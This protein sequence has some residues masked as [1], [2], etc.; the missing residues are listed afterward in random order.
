MS[1]EVQLKVL[2]TRPV[3]RIPATINALAACCITAVCDPMLTIEPLA[4]SGVEIPTCQALA[5]T[6]VAAAELLGN[7]VSDVTI[8]IY[9]VG[10]TTAKTALQHG[11][12][13]VRSAQGD[14][15]TL[16]DLIAS[17]AD[18][19]S[20]RLLHLGSEEVAGDLVET[21][22]VR[23]FCAEHVGI[24]RVREATTFL[25]STISA[26]KGGEVG[27]VLFFSPRSARTFVRLVN[28]QQHT[29]SLRR[30]TAVCL[31]TAVAHE[32]ETAGW[33][34]ILISEQPTMVSLIESV[35]ALGK[36]QRGDDRV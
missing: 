26:F 16:V 19:S 6:S 20:G 3:G 24:Y 29:F 1:S 4:N 14:V 25:S 23:G 15:L 11:F 2:V 34:K 13:N 18:P 22:R 31:S 30:V 9:A 7:Y 8:P 5:I 21:L 32:T 36:R 10:D 12:R 28:L 27:G 35:S 17:V 33:E